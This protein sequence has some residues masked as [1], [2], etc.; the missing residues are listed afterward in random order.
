[1]NRELLRNIS[2]YT[3]ILA[4]Q[5]LIF[6]QFK[7]FGFITPFIYLIIFIHYRISYDRTIL[8]LLGFLIGF[9]VDLSMQT[10]GC[11]TFSTITICYLR[12]RIEKSSFGVNANSPL[13]M[14]KG[15]PLFSRISFF[16]SIIAIHSIIYYTFIFFNISLLSTIFLY[17]FINSIATFIIVWIISRLISNR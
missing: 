17:A 4:L 9:I 2:F 16:L 15:T 1:M 14:I 12:S 5:L 10:Y 13:A 7:L 3:I 8:L 6:N 11:H